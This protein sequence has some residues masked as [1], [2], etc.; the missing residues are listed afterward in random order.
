VGGSGTPT[1]TAPPTG[2]APQGAG[3]TGS[4]GNVTPVGIDGMAG[5][6]AT[7]GTGG[8]GSASPPS[9][10]GASND[11][12]DTGEGGQAG[13]QPSEPEG[14]GGTAAP[15]D[16]DDDDDDDDGDDG[17]GGT[18]PDDGD[19]GDDGQAGTGPVGNAGT[20]N[21]PP[22]PANPD[23]NVPPP[24]SRLEGW[25]SVA[26]RG[27]NTTTGGGNAAMQIVT[28]LAALQAAVAGTNPAVIGV[29]GILAAGDLRIG[30]NKTIIG[31][32]GAEIHGH[33]EINESVNVI[34][35]NIAIVGYGVGNCALDPGFDAAVGC[36]SGDDA[37]I[38]Q[39][40]SH[41]IWIDHCLVRD[42]TDGN[43]DISNAADF[44]T[45]SFTKFMYTPRT[46]NV[47]SDS[48]GAAGHRYSNL[49]GGTDEPDDFDDAN[50]LNVTWHHNWWADNVVERQP[51]IRFGQNHLYN[52]YW[53]SE[54][55]N[56]CVRAGIQS[57]ILLEG[58][59]FDGVDDPH[60]FNNADDQTTANITA[61]NS[62]IYDATTSDQAVGG[63]GPAFTDPP[64]NYVLDNAAG[65][66]ASITNP[67]TG[68]GP[69]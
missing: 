32:C 34:V 30:S 21:V 23:C 28:S 46:D 19:D 39:R 33:V 45:I 54:T 18:P 49:V 55:T 27:V 64:Y 40:N 68:A 35:R 36:S 42:G 48:T 11:G 59:Y 57:Q 17:A 7:S 4:E 52:N 44:V 66:P 14:Q 63:G 61:G 9:S 51:R 26:G 50:A 41:H 22:P 38:I 10:G 3:G 56:Y 69:H 2:A 25:A 29:R 43:L 37:A 5:T 60:E 13:A 24:P 47:G 58:N 31:L 12:V 62:N 65:I 8:S 6:P 15:D 67:A 20:G 53:N 16:G 1:P